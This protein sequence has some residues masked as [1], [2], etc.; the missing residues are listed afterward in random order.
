MLFGALLGNVGIE[1]HVYKVSNLFCRDAFIKTWNIVA[2]TNEILKSHIEW[3]N[4]NQTFQYIDNEMVPDFKF[5]DLT[6]IPIENAEQQ[7]LTKIIAQR[8]CKLDLQKQLFKITV[9]IISIFY[10]EIL[11]H[12]ILFDGWSNSIIL[13][14]WQKCYCNIIADMPI[15]K[16]EKTK[17]K[18][19]VEYQQKYL[20]NI[21]DSQI[22]YWKNYLAPCMEYCANNKLGY[23]EV[24]QKHNLDLNKSQYDE[25]EYNCKELKQVQML[26]RKLQISYASIIY[27][28]WSA[29]LSSLSGKC[30]IL[31]GFVRSGRSIPI[32][33]ID[34]MVGL[35]IETLPFCTTINKSMKLVD[36][37]EH[38]HK[39]LLELN[40]QTHVAF[41]KYEKR[42]F[43]KIAHVL[44]DNIVTIQNYPIPQELYGNERI[45][46]Y[47]KHH[48]SNMKMSLSILM[49]P[50]Y[51][52]TLTYN[53]LYY[54]EE[55]INRVANL[56]R[57]SIVK[58]VNENDDSF[59]VENLIKFI[60]EN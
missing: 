53:S 9:Y 52:I 6:K 39:T 32:Q 41:K 33:G 22:E 45:S 15:S 54:T 24:Y 49:E 27:A 56:L 12:H 25:Y 19:Y 20:K 14:E 23:L 10:M 36:Y 3:E 1:Q 59:R 29:L 40:G 51:T 17:Y 46:L 42:N 50:L 2:D 4:H 11:N 57:M 35:F 58:I 13:N 30:D 43:S 7:M 60:Q 26:G 21:T 31:F 18:S 44:Y 8:D 37:F 55:F 16:E 48:T 38:A 5:I 28:L 34:K 47:K